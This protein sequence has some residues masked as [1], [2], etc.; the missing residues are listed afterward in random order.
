MDL[1]IGLLRYFCFR[2]P[3]LLCGI[4]S[5]AFKPNYDSNNLLLSA[6]MTKEIIQVLIADTKRPYFEQVC[7]LSRQ[8]AGMSLTSA[9]Y[10]SSDGLRLLHVYALRPNWEQNSLS[11]LSPVPL[12][13]ENILSAPGYPN[14]RETIAIVVLPLDGLSHKQQIKNKS[15][16]YDVLPVLVASEPKLA[17]SKRSAGTPRKQ[18]PLQ[19][20]RL[21][22][23]KIRDDASE[24]QQWWSGD[25]PILSNRRKPSY[26]ALWLTGCQI[27]SRRLMISVQ[28]S[29]WTRRNE[30]DCSAHIN[31][32][33]ATRIRAFLGYLVTL[34][35]LCLIS[36]MSTQ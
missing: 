18:L 1:L 14:L 28:D 35:Y 9:P 33:T 4:F 21:A 6:Y 31:N 3:R 32:T 29:W 36:R 5:A 17:F 10:E 2:T 26:A 16:V 7:R 30:I 20:R 8:R 22:G 24:M 15:G 19:I 34:N 13:M 27:L 25:F 12:Q 11:A 23:W